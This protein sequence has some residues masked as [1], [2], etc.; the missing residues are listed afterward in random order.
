V[1]DRL[2]QPYDVSVVP[3]LWTPTSTLTGCPDTPVPI[4]TVTPTVTPTPTATPPCPAEGV[5]LEMPSH[6]FKHPSN[7]YLRA[8]ICSQSPEPL[9]SIP[10]FCLLEYV[11]FYWF[12]PGWT[13]QADWELIDPLVPGTT[14][15]TLIEL[16]TWPSG[17]G[18]GSG[19]R[20][21]AAI[22]DPGITEL[23]GQMGEWEFGWE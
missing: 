10:F 17:V 16:F 13:E 4:P 7:C 14:D 23:I 1:V 6:L 22:T 12:Y 11:G 21:I 9:G 18:S 2:D 20:F 5:T 8:T 3:T 19:A 15:K